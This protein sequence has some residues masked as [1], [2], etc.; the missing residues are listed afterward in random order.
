MYLL[1]VYKS[2]NKVYALL[3]ILCVLVCIACHPQVLQVFRSN[4]SPLLLNLSHLGI[5]SRHAPPLFHS[6]IPQTALTSLMLGG[7]RL[8]DSSMQ[9]LSETLPHLASL[10]TLDLACV[11]MT[12][13][14]LEILASVS[15]RSSVGNGQ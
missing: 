5:Q 14:G 15:P 3:S 7:N 2:W 4:P 8:L 13:R 6:L 1:L 11:G 9:S 10:H 12:H